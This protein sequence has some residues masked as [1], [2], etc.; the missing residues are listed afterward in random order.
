[1]TDRS[2]ATLIAEVRDAMGKVYVEHRAVGVALSERDEKAAADPEDEFYRQMH[3]IAA[4]LDE[5]AA[6][7]ETERAS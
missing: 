3:K 1:M 7:L 6:L 4:A 5:L 2:P